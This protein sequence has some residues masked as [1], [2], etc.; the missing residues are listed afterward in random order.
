MKKI[1][2]IGVSAG[3]ACGPIYRY[4]NQPV[5]VEH[6]TAAD[7]QAELARLETSLA[8]AKTEL[9]A[10]LEAALQRVGAKEAEI[11][12]AHALMLEDPELLDQVA[13][14]IQEKHLSA[15][16]AWFEGTEHYA[17]LLAGMGDEYLSARSAD[18]RDVAQRVLRILTGRGQK[19]TDLEDPAVVVAEDLTPSDT[20]TFDPTKV[21]AFCT[22][23]GGPTSHVAILSKALGIPAITGIGSWLAELQDGLVAIVDGS[24]GVMVL[25]PDETTR[26]EY[27]SLSASFQEKFA[28]ALASAH[29][30]AI[31]LDGRRVEV[32]ANVA[33]VSGASKALEF[34]AEGIGLL[35]TEFLFLDRE[36][37]P[38][39]E[40]QAEDYRAVLEVFGKNPVVIRTLDIG[41]DK[42]A[43]YLKMAAELNPFLGVRGTRLALV[44]PKVFQN[45][46]RALLRAG[47]GH[48]LK[49]MCPMV[50]SLQEVRAIHEHVNQARL[51]LEES[52]VEYAHD[53]EI[54]IMVEIPS[55]AVMADVLAPEV[56]FFSIGTNDLSQYTLAADRT[57]P[58][59]SPLADALDPSV[60]RLISMVT[61]A[62]HAH[63][64]W[65]GLCGEL[66]GDPLAAPVLLGIGI[67]EFSMNP[68][69]VP[70]VKQALRRFSTDQ[71]R[72]IAEKAL[73]LPTV[74][75]VRRYLESLA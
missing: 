9:E 16:E 62:A 14:A 57:N 4:E 7:P 45:Q 10:V 55:A 20:V 61:R 34:G 25:A 50:G 27:Q 60:L 19:S 2:G 23:K 31:T 51:A 46:L 58:D 56:D 65:V 36:T 67:D 33:A 42:P 12:S 35:R 3:I 48:N 54:G 29:Q 73:Q 43:P 71:A 63:G 21:L 68:R 49:I 18:V 26:A 8:T 41:G 22:A 40:E 69:A 47:L 64:K 30:P 39:E 52:G 74:A 37:E 6:K 59:V 53:V 17:N 44:H 13:A 38:T 66:A 72:Q 24:A 1:T 32:V 11:F 28:I 75:D 5:V 70:L 15:E